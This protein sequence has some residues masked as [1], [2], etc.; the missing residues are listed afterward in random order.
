MKNLLLKLLFLSSLCLAACGGASKGKEYQIG[1]DPSWYPL[2]LM[3]M[4]SNILAFTQ[5]LFVEMSH[6]EN[7]NFVQSR[8]NWDNLLL[9]LQQKKEDGMLS[10]MQP[11]LFTVKTYDFSDLMIKTGPVLVVP[12]G[13]DITSISMMDGKEIGVI[14]GESSISFS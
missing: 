5:E 3:G 4:E 8:K 1:I 7:V 9:G 10:S 14:K 2:S 11:H 6:L 13:S 12:K